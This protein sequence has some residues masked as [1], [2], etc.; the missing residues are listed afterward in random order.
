MKKE[1]PQEA[2]FRELLPPALRSIAQVDMSYSHYFRVANQNLHELY[3]SRADL[4]KC[5]EWYR[6]SREYQESCH[7][8][9]RCEDILLLSKDTIF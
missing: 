1:T 8:A 7:I 9:L 5:I 4:N 3:G 6:S 2:S